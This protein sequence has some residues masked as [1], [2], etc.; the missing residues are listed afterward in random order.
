MSREEGVLSTEPNVDV[1]TTCPDCKRE[2]SV[3]VPRDGYDRWQRGEYIQ[4]ALS[5]LTDDDRERLL[6]GICPDCFEQLFGNEE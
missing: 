5:G 2:R 4:R 3:S 6:T 1:Q